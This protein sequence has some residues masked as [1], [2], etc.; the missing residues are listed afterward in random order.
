MVT[1]DPWWRFGPSHRDIGGRP[2]SRPEGLTRGHG[3]ARSRTGILMNFDQPNPFAFSSDL[4]IWLN[5]RIVP[6][7]EAAIS[8]FEHCLLYGDAWFEA[9]AATA[10]RC[11]A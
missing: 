8:I 1:H 10:E 4:K 5:G 3:F 11:S 6:A 9:S 7:A 2:H